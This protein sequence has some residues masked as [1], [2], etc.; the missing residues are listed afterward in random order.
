MGDYLFYNCTSLASANVP[1]GVTEIKDYTF[2]YCL[3]LNSVNFPSSVT[4][5]STNALYESGWYDNQAD[6]VLYLGT[7]AYGYKGDMPEETIINITP[8]T[9]I[10][11]ESAF[12]GYLNLLAVGIPESVDSI[13]STAF[14]GCLGLAAISCQSMTAPKVAPDAF[15]SLTG[16][17]TLLIVPDDAVEGYKAH[18]VWGKFQVMGITEYKNRTQEPGTYAS[19]SGGDDPDGIRSTN[20][21]AWTSE[22]F[23]LSGRRQNAPQR[24]MNII[25]MS[26]GTTRKVMVK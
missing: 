6:G 3:A 16:S 8:G 12:S 14:A 19:P 15:G 7:M 22:V 4:K 9:T 23:D 1:N 2:G 26:D 11:N 13:C 24:G 25:R 10:I 21:D 20:S 18:P 17:Y 5:V